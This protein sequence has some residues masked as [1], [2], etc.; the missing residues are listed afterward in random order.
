MEIKN[1][2]GV[3]IVVVYC[4]SSYAVDLNGARCT[5]QVSGNSQTYEMKYDF[6]RGHFNF[7]NSIYSVGVAKT[8]TEVLVSFTRVS[9]NTISTRSGPTQWTWAGA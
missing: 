4:S 1:I 5:V 9:D 6:A 3:L 2:F 7:G 8:D